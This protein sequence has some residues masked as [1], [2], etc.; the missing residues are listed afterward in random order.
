MP[1]YRDAIKKVLQHEGGFVNHPNDKGGPTNWG[2]TQKTY[3]EYMSKITGRPYQSTLDEIKSMPI[4]NAIN[5]YKFLYWDKM[6]GDKIKKYAIAA[7]I[8]DQAINR[9]TTAAVKQA[10]RVLKNNFNYPSI[11]EDGVAG[12]GTLTALNTIDEAKF[13]NS[14]LQESILAYK[15]IVQN[16][17]TQT[18][19]LNGWLKRVESLRSYV[20]QNIGKINATTV[21]I[22]VGV[23]LALGI[24]SYF[25]YKF[26][27]PQNRNTAKTLKIQDKRY[28]NGAI[29]TT[30]RRVA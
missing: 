17:P 26:M 15:K 9:G 3:N 13:L 27:K 12:A 2:V 28:A 22:G 11:A 1:D 21:G 30:S 7:A 10:Q 29:E 14:Y 4:G 25:I 24:G 23:I 6:S 5:I 8:F 20:S 19:F 18:V 16:N